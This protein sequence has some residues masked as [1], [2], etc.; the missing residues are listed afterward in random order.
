MYRVDQSR[1]DLSGTW[2]VCDDRNEYNLTIQIPG[3]VHSAL[4]QSG[5]IPDPFQGEQEASIQWVGK[6]GWSL[7]RYFDMSAEELGRARRWHLE[8]G[9]V[10]TFALIMVNGEPVFQSSNMFVPVRCDIGHLLRP[11]RNTLTLVFRS[12]EEEAEMRAER[13]PY[14]VPHQIYPYQSMHRN[15]VRKVQCHS[16]WDWGIALMAYG[17]YG[18]VELRP[19]AAESIVNVYGIPRKKKTSDRTWLL[20]VCVEWDRLDRTD[21]LLPPLDRFPESPVSVSLINP[22]GVSVDCTTSVRMEKPGSLILCLQVENP[23]L[24]W[25]RGYGEQPLYQVHVHFGDEERRFTTAFRT[26]EVIHEADDIGK[27]MFFRI[28]GRDIWAKG[29]N[30]IPVDAFPGRQTPERYEGLLLDACD[31]N[32]NMI[33]VWGGGQY[34]PDLFYDL[35]DRLGLLIWQDFMFSCSL[36]PSEDWF[37]QE[38]VLE[39]EAQGKRLLS[40]PSI[41]IWC[42]N[43]E[44]V[45][46]LNWYEVSR[47]NRSRYLNDYE[48]LN[49]GVI[50]AVIQSLDDTRVF[51][52]SSP[53]AGE[54]DFS[55]N[56]H[57]DTSG[58]MH[59]WSVWH[60]GKSFNS[61]L[62]VVPR[63]CSEFGFQSFPS[64]DTIRSVV[65][66]SQLNPT[67]PEL[68][69]HQR[70]PR[71][72]SVILETISRYFRFPFQFSDFIYISQIQQAVAIETA[73]NY[74][75]SNRPV[76]M[77]SLFWQLND[78]W[79]VVSWSSIEYDGR[80][81]LLQYHAK[82]FYSP[83]NMVF[84]EKEGMISLSLINDK[85][86]PV[87]GSVHL[88][89]RN[90]KGEEIWSLETE[91]L[92]VGDCSREI[93]ST[94]IKKLPFDRVEAFLYADFIG[95]EEVERAWTLLDAYKKIEFLQPRFTVVRTD[96]NTYTIH[97]EDAPAF[98]VTLESSRPGLQPDDNGF[99]MLPGESKQ[100]RFKPI[101]GLAGNTM[102]DEASKAIAELKI[103]SIIDT[104]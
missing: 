49:T 103:R 53:A 9:A 61:Y 68:E 2:F 18:H 63:F 7:W 29:S 28:N 11:G 101:R 34:E 71:G 73:V 16:S 47:N 26:V 96:V 69:H 64:L 38:V 35:C 22:L 13:L 43:N 89:A 10:D 55:D 80:W 79:P 23:H 93:W 91:V 19:S 3:D 74:W 25:P 81:K 59:Y 70:S 65:S 82:R 21:T 1:I 62:D 37:K 72:N 67:S 66:E 12:A 32:M 20:P 75:R 58:D 76:C 4:L 51:W 31:A 48:Q 56:W 45:G 94:P 39:I 42:G 95:K 83:Q 8:L 87:S 54:G 40:H 24:W 52:P 90:W 78:L 60:E 97:C 36:Y 30:W 86:I 77:G 41:A 99:F 88:A 5:K 84:I 57:D 17:I 46:A 27:T 98:W 92:V 44:N 6:R 102:K 33:R 104:Y 14:P 15:L 100:I 85:D 50:G